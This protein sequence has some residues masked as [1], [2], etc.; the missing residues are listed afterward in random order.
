[1]D[2]RMEWIKS[3]Y[4]NWFSFTHDI[5]YFHSQYTK[6]CILTSKRSRRIDSIR[7]RFFMWNGIFGSKDLMIDSSQIVCEPWVTYWDLSSSLSSFV[8]ILTCFRWKRS[9][10]FLMIAMFGSRQFGPFKRIASTILS[11]TFSSKFFGSLIRIHDFTPKFG[12]SWPP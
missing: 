4:A 6:P 7:T 1:M 8:K 12:W 5:H 10:T 2:M 3:T 9:K 11:G